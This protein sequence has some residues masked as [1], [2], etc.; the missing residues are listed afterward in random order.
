MCKR[1]HYMTDWYRDHR[2]Q[3]CMPW[4]IVSFLC[5]QTNVSSLSPSYQ[6][7]PYSARMRTPIV[8]SSSLLTF[9]QHCRPAGG[10]AASARAPGTRH[11]SIF[12][13]SHLLLAASCV[14][15]HS[16]RIAYSQG[17]AGPDLSSSRGHQTFTFWKT[18]NP[19]TVPSAKGAEYYP[20]R[21]RRGGL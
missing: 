8:P 4:V 3:L 12:R 11:A 7:L 10:A 16:E 6:S 2:T 15:L 21:R 5:H 1:Y 9:T 17:R 18:T 14:I 13:A 19:Q 20:G